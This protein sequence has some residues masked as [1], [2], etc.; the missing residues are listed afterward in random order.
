MKKKKSIFSLYLIFLEML[1]TA[2][3]KKEVIFLNETKYNRNK[4]L[5]LKLLTIKITNSKLNWNEKTY[6]HV[7]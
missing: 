5:K 3:N 1:H 6:T 4:L 2:Y 7:Y